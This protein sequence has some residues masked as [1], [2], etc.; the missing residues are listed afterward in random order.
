VRGLNQ[1]RC[2]DNR[3]RTL[4]GAL[5]HCLEANPDAIVMGELAD[6]ETAQLACRA[7]A[8]GTLI[9]TGSYAPDAVTAVT[10]L[11]AQAPPAVAAAPLSFV[12]AQRLVR[13]VCPHCA[14]EKS[15]EFRLERVLRSIFTWPTDATFRKGK[16]CPQCGQLG[17]LGRVGVFEAL[18]VDE[19]LRSLLLWG[20]APSVLRGSLQAATHEGIEDATFQRVTHGEVNADELRSL[21]MRVGVALEVMLGAEQD[22]AGRMEAETGPLELGFDDYTGGTEFE[23]E[24]WDDIKNVVSALA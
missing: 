13:K 6:P 3:I 19:D 12:L 1:V 21:G 9:V 8:S 7:A 10:R 20:A 15:P 18:P 17:T 23:I 22:T 24:T 2:A 4:A 14:V 5:E 11:L 16:G